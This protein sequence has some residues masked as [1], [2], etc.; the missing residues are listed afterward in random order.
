MLGLKPTRDNV[1][2]E[3][4]K[5]LQSLKFIQKFEDEPDDLTKELRNRTYDQFMKDPF[6]YKQ[7]E[8][9]EMEKNL[10][11]LDPFVEN[12][13][14]IQHDSEADRGES[15][16]NRRKPESSS[17][18][19]SDFKASEHGRKNTLSQF[20]NKNTS[21]TNFRK[22]SFTKVDKREPKKLN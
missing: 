12:L 7:I 4:F 1:Q 20:P 21:T 13:K 5:Y 16:Q 6:G 22:M 18:L 11:K 9:M 3:S 19:D 2:Q 14:F 8:Q 17:D 15:K 10:H